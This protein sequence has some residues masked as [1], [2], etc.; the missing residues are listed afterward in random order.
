M[1]GFFTVALLHVALTS[2][3]GSEYQKAFNQAEEAGKP[4]LVLVGVGPEYS[5]MK[6][7]TMPE[8]KRA[9]GLQNVIFTEVD[10][11]AI[12]NLTR[13]LQRGNPLP[14]LVLYTPVGKLWRRTHLAGAPSPGEIST[15]LKREI[16]KGHEV[17]A[18]TLRRNAGQSQSQSNIMYSYSSGSS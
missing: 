14:Q 7:E 2:T 15:F 8:L 10:A 12:P 11:K 18:R 3:T 17:A 13:K 1:H 5:E 16:A 6:Q 9:G 4:F